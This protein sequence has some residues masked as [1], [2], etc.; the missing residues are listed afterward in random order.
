MLYRI[1]IAGLVLAAVNTCPHR[2]C[3]AEAATDAGVEADAAALCD[4]AEEAFLLGKTNDAIA[5]WSKA[6]KIFGRTKND[7]GLARANSGLGAAYLKLSQLDQAERSFAEARNRF[8][9]AGDLAGQA[10]CVSNLADTALRRGAFDEALGYRKQA[11]ELRGQL[12]DDLGKAI[13]LVGMG[14]VLSK[15]GLRREAVET[16]TEAFKIFS[17]ADSQE[18]MAAA[19]SGIGVEYYR[20]GAYDLALLCH[21]ESLRMHTTISDDFQQARDLL[22]IGNVHQAVCNYAGAADNY[23][24]AF[25]IQK[26][27]GDR[28]GAA[29]ALLN[30]GVC[31]KNQG[32]YSKSLQ[33]LREALNIFKETGNQSGRADCYTNLGVLFKTIGAYDRAETCYLEALRIHSDIGDKP[34]HAADIAN[35]GVLY[36][37]SGRH[38][39]ALEHFEQAE[40]IF[41]QTQNR[42]EAAIAAGNAAA[43]L[44]LQKKLDDARKKLDGAAAEFEKL[45]FATGLGHCRLAA[46]AIQQQGG[47]LDGACELFQQALDISEGAG[48]PDLASLSRGALARTLAQRGRTAE[49]AEMYSQ[50]IS[51]VEK[52]RRNVGTFQLAS[53]FLDK[54]SVFYYQA[55]ALLARQAGRDPEAAA[56][57]YNYAEMGRARGFVDMLAEAGIDI[58][59]GADPDLLLSEKFCLARMASINSTIINETAQNAPAE[60]IQALRTKLQET[61]TAWDSLQIMLKQQ[62]PRYGNL[63]YPEP[64]TAGQVQ[65]ML[66]PD[67]ALLEYAVAG[68]SSGDEGSFLFAL[69]KDDIR[70][71]ELPPAAEIRSAVE[72]FREIILSRRSRTYCPAAYQLYRMLVE[73]AAELIAD[74][75]QLIIVPDGF[76]HYVAF[77]C[78]LTEPAA[79]IDFSNLPYL[80]RRAVIRY[81][82][83]A[84]A[85]AQ[86]LGQRT[87]AQREKEILI[88]AD[89]DYGAHEDDV[90]L[91][92][93]NTLGAAAGLVRLPYSSLEARQISAVFPPESVVLLDRA[94]ASEER[95][96]SMPLDR[97]R[98]INFATHAVLDAQRPEFSS[99]V[100]AQT[101]TEEDGFL[102]MQEIFNLKL[103]ADLVVLSACSTARGRLLNGEGM[104][105]LCRAFFYAGTPSVVAS[106]WNVSDASTAQLVSEL[107]AGLQAHGENPAQAL[108]DA[109]LKLIN[110]HKTPPFA[111]VADG[112][113]P[114]SMEIVGSYSHPFYWASFVHIGR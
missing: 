28:D 57:A 51:Q 48:D 83:S 44:A 86:I 100:L 62:C 4:S 84:T 17:A 20:L 9:S 110:S 61:E 97:F 49:A 104:I 32:N 37:M 30:L 1:I 24:K 26:Q 102:Q 43:S 96:K 94:D 23:A 69:T 21:E 112:A 54:R 114:E 101:S 64:L 12:N 31:S 5:A 87:P 15:K 10:S 39:K 34:N 38:D 103:N 93:R 7:A 108:R 78:L 27:V 42:R 82:P 66:E 45:N 109:K 35:L 74:K 11:L 22:N 63:Y 59:E 55:M 67:T 107:F 52:M 29:R 3:R 18:G 85:F 91:A 47:N 99:I 111:V 88:C 19:T 113:S 40:K 76:I 6:V 53:S 106:L 105:G 13:D 68:E 79:K 41:R 36:A 60:R 72:N 89:P 58:R 77:D 2:W 90:R 70:V 75:R 16:Y 92:M 46:G 81:A 80:L 8:A 25:H 14:H 56:A 95:L 98:Y 50:A 71:Y 33:Q 73:P 65:Q